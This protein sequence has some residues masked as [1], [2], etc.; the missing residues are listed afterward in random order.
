VIGD[1]SEVETVDLGPQ[2]RVEQL[3]NL[4]VIHGWEN[5]P[6]EK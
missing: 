4:G 1:V 3:G 6:N 5:M 2:G